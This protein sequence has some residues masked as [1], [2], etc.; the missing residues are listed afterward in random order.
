MTRKPSRLPPH[1]A[2]SFAAPPEAAQG[3]SAAPSRIS[4]PA[5]ECRC[6]HQDCTG[7]MRRGDRP[8]SHLHQRSMRVGATLCFCKDHCLRQYQGNLVV[9]G[10]PQGSRNIQSRCVRSQGNLHT[11]RALLTPWPCICAR[12]C[13]SPVAVR[14]DML[15]TAAPQ[16]AKAQASVLQP[17]C[18]SMR[19]K[20]SAEPNLEQLV[21]LQRVDAVQLHSRHTRHQGRECLRVHG[22]PSIKA[23]IVFLSCPSSCGQ[24]RLQECNTQRRWA[25]QCSQVGLITPCHS[26]LRHI[27]DRASNCEVSKI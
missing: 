25:G 22:E 24:G 12:P 15:A 7:C 4:G 9:L 2:G 13:S 17:R 23:D 10:T 11:C 8:V 26:F 27:V 3:S 6:A 1:T 21:Q 14:I 20:T 19:F 18:R 16:Q 5:E